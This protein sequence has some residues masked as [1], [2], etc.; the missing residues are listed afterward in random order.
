MTLRRADPSLV[1]GANYQV[2]L[3]GGGPNLEEWVFTVSED[4]DHTPP[5]LPIA[6]PS[7]QS[8]G[9]TWSVSRQELRFDFDLE[10]GPS[11]E[12]L[13]L[14]VG[15]LSA[16]EDV[17]FDEEAADGVVSLIAHPDDSVLTVGRSSCGTNW[18]DAEE[19]DSTELRYGVYD[20]AGNFSGWS[21][22]ITLTVIEPE[23][24]SCSA[25]ASRSS[26]FAGALLLL[27]GIRRRAR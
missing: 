3:D 5:A 21:E 24:C 19:G 1:G 7:D 14:I 20:L 25:S 22:P 9:P 27:V 15:I 2:L 4:E 11:D 10:I 6:T 12:P 18:P 16:D 13:G 26:L 8:G 23:G 17:D